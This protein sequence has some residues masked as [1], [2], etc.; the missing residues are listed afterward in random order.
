[1]KKI[2]GFVVALL[3][4]F[5]I[6]TNFGG[7]N[8]QVLGND[9]VLHVYTIDDVATGGG[10][11]SIPFVNE[12]DEGL[13]INALLDVN[14]DGEFQTDTEWVVQNQVAHPYKDYRNN[15]IVDLTNFDDALG[16]RKTLIVVSKED[17]HSEWDG[18]VRDNDEA[19]LGTARLSYFDSSEILGINVP[20][21]RQELKRGPA[22]VFNF[23]PLAHADDA[24]SG[25]F[26]GPPI[27]DL[28]QG[29]MEC[30]PVSTTNNLISLAQEHGRGD[31]LPQDPREMIE[32]LKTDMKYHEGSLGVLL[33]D[34]VS[35]KDAFVERY[36]LPIKSSKIDNPTTEQLTDAIARGCVVELS[37]GF[38]RSKSGKPNTGHVV[39]LVGV[40]GGGNSV[41]VHDPATPGGGADTYEL[42]FKAKAGDKEFQGINYP[43]W[44]GISIIDAA[45]VQCWVGV[46]EATTG[47]QIDGEDTSRVEMLVIDGSYYPKKQFRAADPDAC[48]ATHWHVPTAYGLKTKTSKEVVSKDDPKPNECGFGKVGEV[49]EE[50][51][52]ITF[53]QSTELIK[54]L[55]L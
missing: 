39:S 16:D 26:R 8:T 18:S 2:I 19:F 45:V 37:M 5:F 40:G 14:G 20:G 41:Q 38:I 21:A 52:D 54:H 42:P 27:P 11:L 46:E 4:L 12:S 28:P 22:P 15:F 53:E 23:T 1:M 30:M 3:L 48:K 50:F 13:F 6:F 9:V 29:P 17:V 55:P 44:D 24:S 43:M 49:K 51:V 33:Q 31:D 25:V 10:T 36:N 34:M 32:E 47:V 35:G 7:G